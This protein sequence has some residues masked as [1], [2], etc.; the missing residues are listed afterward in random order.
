MAVRHDT[1]QHEIQRVLFD[2]AERRRTIN[3]DAQL[4]VVEQGLDHKVDIVFASSTMR[5][6]L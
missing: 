3:R 2:A 6:R 1:E 5:M 4:V